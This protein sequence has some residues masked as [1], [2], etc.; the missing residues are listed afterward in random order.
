MYVL[1]H[2]TPPRISVSLHFQSVNLAP[3]GTGAANRCRGHGLWRFH[4]GMTRP[5]LLK[6]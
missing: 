4:A 6:V 5:G 1:V 3:G 2:Y